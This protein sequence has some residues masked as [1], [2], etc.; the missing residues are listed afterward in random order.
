MES[1]FPGRNR[2][3]PALILYEYRDLSGEAILLKWLDENNG[4][5]IGMAM[6]P[7]KVGR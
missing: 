6:M 2:G 1:S 4:S 5:L 3:N 7:E